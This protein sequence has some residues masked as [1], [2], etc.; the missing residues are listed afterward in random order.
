ME[1]HTHIFEIQ[2]FFAANDIFIQRPV[3]EYDYMFE[4][5]SIIT[6]I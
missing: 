3:P 4:I 5:Y 1:T 6:Y 2:F